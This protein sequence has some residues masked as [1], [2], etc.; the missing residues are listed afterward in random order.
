MTVDSRMAGKKNKK[1][2]ANPSKAPAKQETGSAA[3]APAPEETQVLKKKKSQRLREWAKE[4]KA[5][6]RPPPDSEA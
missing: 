4:M 5:Y 1:S 2:A 6:F 3:P